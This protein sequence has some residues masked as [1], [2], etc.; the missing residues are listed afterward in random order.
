M[1]NY[2]TK[3]P[4]E[5]IFWSDKEP[6]GAVGWIVLHNRVN[7]LAG[8][9][10]CMHPDVTL[11]EIK[12]LAATM[13]YKNALQQ[14]AL[15]GGKGGVRFDP[16]H[17]E[18]TNVL[19]RFL[20]ENI[21]VIKSTWCTGGDLYT[22]TEEITKILRQQCGLSSPFYC[23]AKKI[24]FDPIESTLAKFHQCLNDKEWKDY[25]IGE[26]ITGFSMFETLRRVYPKKGAKIVVQGFGKIGKAFCLYAKQYYQIAGICEQNWALYNEQGL[27]INRLLSGDREI[28]SQKILKEECQSNEEFLI[29]FLKIAKAEVFCPCATRYAITEEVLL[30]LKEQCKVILSGANNS[31]SKLALVGEAINQGIMVVPEWLSNCGNALFFMEALKFKGEIESWN[32]FIK[33]AVSQR[34]HHFILASIKIAKQKKTHFYHACYQLADQMLAES[35]FTWRKAS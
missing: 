10:L 29:S 27:D 32:Q 33:A 31:F 35:D 11:A 5:V 30:A 34:I 2:Y 18:A 7:G 16:H 24:S 20:Q 13:R 26:M 21:S 15:G 12:D 6:T 1:S 25:T 19:A 23:L 3:E 9:G 4:A 28:H 22:T 8:G 17:P 14:P